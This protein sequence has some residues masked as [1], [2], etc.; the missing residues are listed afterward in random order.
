MDVLVK[1]HSER[2]AMA[3]REILMTAAPAAPAVLIALGELK[4]GGD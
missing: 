4:I 1:S 3:M 2:E